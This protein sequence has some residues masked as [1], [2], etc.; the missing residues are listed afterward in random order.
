MQGSPKINRKENNMFKN[1][2]FIA[3]FL[4]PVFIFVACNTKKSNIP[5]ENDVAFDTLY[6]SQQIFL[7]DDPSKSSC[8]ME[9]RLVYPVASKKLNIDTLTNLWTSCI[10]GQSY[11]AMSLQQAAKSYIDTYFQRYRQDAKDYRENSFNKDPLSALT[12]GSYSQSEEDENESQSEFYSYYE[13]LTDTVTFNQNDLISLQVRRV[14]NKGGR[15]SYETFRN[16]VID[17]KTGNILSEKDIFIEGYE[18]QLRRIII[19]KLLKQNGVN[20]ISELEQLGYFG[21]N[22]IVPNRNF[23]I[24]AK[25]ITFIFNKGEYSAYLISA[26]V[27]FIPYE[28]I[29]HLLRE[30]TTVWKLAEI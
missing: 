28:E 19:N 10:F 9:I 22:E 3:L 30:N 2:T 11:T 25:G 14:S 21:V 8:N 1:I 17:L 24:D 5:Q 12:D 16:F 26:P 29:R 13:T 20:D 27:I 18:P 4:I 7:D 23:L 6:L 15:E